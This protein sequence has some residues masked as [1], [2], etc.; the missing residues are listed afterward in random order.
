MG[1]NISRTGPETNGTG[2]KVGGTMRDEDANLKMRSGRDE[3]GSIPVL[4]SSL[5]YR[6]NY[7]W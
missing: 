6:T 2:P 1:S 3:K 5:Y 4:N 7:D